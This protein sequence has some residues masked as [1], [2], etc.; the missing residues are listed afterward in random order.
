V[1]YFGIPH[2]PKKLP[3]P[4]DILIATILSQNTNDR[5]SY[6]AY[7]NLKEKYS[8]VNELADSPRIEIEK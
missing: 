4:I 6:Q 5:N 2:R 1:N 3:N 7:R 8:S